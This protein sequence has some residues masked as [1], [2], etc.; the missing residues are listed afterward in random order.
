MMRKIIQ[1]ILLLVTLPLIM[2]QAQE[3]NLVLLFN[4]GISIP[5]IPD[6]FSNNWMTGFNGGI[7]LG[8]QLGNNSQ[9]IFHVNYNYHLFDKDNYLEQIGE[10]NSNLGF[11]GGS[12][13]IITAYI[14]S[15]AI[16]IPSRIV[17][18]YLI[19]GVGYM[20]ISRSNTTLNLFSETFTIKGK[21]FGVFSL[22]GGVGISIAMSDILALFA[23]ANYNVGFN[24]E[25]TTGF[26]P[27]KL[28]LAI[29][30]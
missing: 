19:L 11:D 21:S 27:I 26:I 7:G 13:S 2:L 1:Y 18:P 29:K 14:I 22:V 20:N 6:R 16:F 30:L 15:K 4:T 3:N 17:S 5:S 8:Y 12:T 10:G 9:L 23:E 28:G 25:E 24:K